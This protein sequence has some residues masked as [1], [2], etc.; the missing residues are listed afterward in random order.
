MTAKKTQIETP[1]VPEGWN[2]GDKWTLDI[3]DQGWEFLRESL[4]DSGE[5]LTMEITVE[6]FHNGRKVGLLKRTVKPDESE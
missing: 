2:L 1:I 5:G 4:D 3:E 6:I